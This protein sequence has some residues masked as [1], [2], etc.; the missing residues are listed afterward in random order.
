MNILSKITSNEYNNRLEAILDTK[1]YST[2]VKNLLL[3]MLY[4]IENGY[5]DYKTVKIDAEDKSNYIEKILQIIQN[6]CDE[7]KVVT[8]Q[9]IK[10]KPLEEQNVICITDE[11][12]GSILVYANE[13]DLLYS[14]FE[15]DYKYNQK[16]KNIINPIIYNI[17]KFYCI[18]SCIDRSEIIRDFD[19]WSWNNNIKSQENIDINFIFQIMQILLGKNETKK[20]LYIPEEIQKNLNGND[21]FKRYMYI[22][23]LTI[24]GKKD[25]NL[26]QTLEKMKIEKEQFQNL[27]NDRKQFVNFVTDEKKRL[28]NDIKKIDE[29]LNDNNKLRYEYNARNEKLSNKEKIFSISHLAEKLE[30]ERAEKLELIKKNNKI[31]EP[32]EFIKQKEKNE[33]DISSLKII[34]EN[35][36][37]S[38]F[39]RKVKIEAQTI[40]LKKFLE[41]IEKA[42]S[43]KLLSLMYKYR[44]YCVLP[45]SLNKE[46]KD[47]QELKSQLQDVTNSLI[48]NG[49][50]KQIIVNFSDSTSVCYSILKFIFVSKIVKLEEIEVMINK[51]AN[52]KQTNDLDTKIRVS[53]YDLKDK[54]KTYEET[55][56]HL[57]LIKVKFNKKIKVFL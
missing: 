42:N 56:K 37:N 13:L 51:L 19:G 50:D 10:S 45:V 3:S 4:K 27:I 48:D 46:I 14:I 47:I 55:V 7:I 2:E 6:E 52:K 38:E 41:K 17:Q 11:Q 20:M 25:D 57:K 21:E 49:I 15:I 1:N 12:R 29:I 26:I 33:H 34:I 30:L 40:F 39:E 16:E 36:Q 28:N 8:P 22:L 31:L 5:E 54:E 35:V 18:A 23:I 53:I 44:Y 9:T 43:Q 32:L 24:M